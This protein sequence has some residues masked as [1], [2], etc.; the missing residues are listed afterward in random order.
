MAAS[1]S[2]V[3]RAAAKEF[4]QNGNDGRSSPTFRETGHS[5]VAAQRLGHAPKR[6]QPDASEEERT[7]KIAFMRAHSFQHGAL[8]IKRSPSGTID[9]AR[10]EAAVKLQRFVRRRITKVRLHRRH[11][12]ERLRYEA[13]IRHGVFRLFN[14][15]T[16]LALMLLALTLSANSGNRLGMRTDLRGAFDLD[17][18]VT[19]TRRD[20]FEKRLENI[21]ARS[22]NYFPLSS[23]RF[24]SVGGDK[25]FVRDLRKFVA[26]ILLSNVNLAV[27]SSFSVSVWVRT[28]PQFLGGYIIRKPPGQ[29]GDRADAACWG[30]FLDAHKGAALRFGSHDDL[31]GHYIEFAAD[32]SPFLPN[33]FTLLTMVVRELEVDF[34]LNL[35]H[36]GRR[37]LPRP[38]TDCHNGGKGMFV[39]DGNLELG[40]LRSYVNA[41]SPSTIQEIFQ[42]GTTLADMS[43]G[44]E[45]SPVEKSQLDLLQSDVADSVEKMS[46]GLADAR[47]A[48]SASSVIEQVIAA[49]DRRAVANVQVSYHSPVMQVGETPSE[50]YD[51]SGGVHQGRMDTTINRTYYQILTGPSRLAAT[52]DEDA[53]YLTSL[54]TFN[55]TG[56]TLTWWYRH[57]NCVS[58]NCGLYFMHAF[59]ESGIQEHSYCWSIWLENDAL[60]YEREEG[61]GACRVMG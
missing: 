49:A 51:S 27:L 3:S 52:T 1:R 59:D 2:A 17:S 44:S 41:L 14:Q 58:S 36:Q 55:G 50:S 16:I 34:Y 15:A 25:M 46:T 60:W 22:K 9:D 40:Q 61:S 37:S 19:I 8:P 39:G 56:A 31:N 43:T 13:E 28:S 18:L 21:S 38:V 42:L 53:R 10:W 26:P 45:P 30:L 47:D 54:P 23:R 6:M 29:E 5:V 24:S 7:R 35:A 32:R 20:E 12:S 48:G 57:I 33:S 4:S 11:L